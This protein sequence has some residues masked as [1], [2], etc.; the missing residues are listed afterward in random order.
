[1]SSSS[2]PV[3]ASPA[4]A[5]SRPL[6][7]MVR[8]LKYTSTDRQLEYLTIKLTRS[9]FSRDEYQRAIKSL[10]RRQKISNTAQ[11]KKRE[12]ERILIQQEREAER[13]AKEQARIVREQ[14]KQQKTL[15]KML[16]FTKVSEKAYRKYGITAYNFGPFGEPV[17][18][19]NDENMN[20]SLGETY[21]IT[22]KENI[23]FIRRVLLTAIAD[24]RK[25][26]PTGGKF[27]VQFRGITYPYDSRK[28]W[29]D[30]TEDKIQSFI[31]AVILWAETNSSPGEVNEK[32]ELVEVQYNFHII[33]I[34]VKAIRPLAGGCRN[35]E[36]KMKIAGA[37]VIDH[38][39]RGKNN[40][41]FTCCSKE[42]AEKYTTITR[43]SEKFFNDIRIKYSIPVDAM[44]DT[45][46]AIR[47][48][49]GEF[50]KPICI[51]NES[52]NAVAG[53]KTAQKK[54][55]LMNEHY[56]EYVGD[57]VEVKEC[58]KC[59]VEYMSKHDAR[60]CAMRRTYMMKQK[61]HVQERFVKMKSEKPGYN[62]QGLVLHYDIE[63][64]TKN[65]DKRHTPYIVGYCYYD[66]EGKQVY[67]TITGDR[68]MEQFY[69]FLGSE[70]VSH[71]KFIN[72]YKGSI[73]DH[74]YLMGVAWRDENAN[75][76]DTLLMNNGRILKAEIQGKNL[77]DLGNHLTG[78]LKQNLQGAGCAIQKGDIDHNTTNAWSKMPEQL[79]HDVKM[80]L[81]K[82]VLGL[83]ELYNKINADMY[84][85]EEVNLCDFLTTSHCAYTLWA[86]K[87]LDQPVYI[88]KPEQDKFIRQ[89]IYGGRCYKNKNRFTSAQYEAVKNGTLTNIEEIDDY[90]VYLDVVSLYPTSMMREYPVGLPENTTDY[91]EGKL[92]IY[93]INYKPNKSL[94]TPVLPRRVENSLKWDLEDGTGVYTSVDIENAKRFGYDIEVEYGMYWEES[95]P[96][97]KSYIEK[98]YQKKQNSVKDTAPYTTAK[99]YLN[100][101]YGKM[102]QRPIYT[103]TFYPKNH[104]ELQEVMCG[105]I[106]TEM[107]L[108]GDRLVVVGTPRE[109]EAV[110]RCVSKPTF[111]GAFILGYSREIMMGHIHNT[112]PDNTMENLFSYTDTDSLMTHVKSMANVKTGK[113]LG[114]LDNDLGTG[115]KIVRAIWISPKL[116]MLEYCY[117]DEKLGKVVMKNK[118][119]GKGLN[120]N[121]LTVE[122]Y[123]RMDAGQSIT[124]VADFQ[125]KRINVKRNKQEKSKD[126]FSVYH[127]NDTDT[128]AKGQP[129]LQKVVNTVAWKGRHFTDDNNS[130]PYGHNLIQHV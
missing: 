74:Y 22:A 109:E 123:E 70:D 2:A 122:L 1:M 7:E 37:E 34:I 45:M 10:N 18:H 100:G 98:F 91:K 105:H 38:Q 51:L 104:M 59:G 113:N 61:G 30:I 78:T 114:D 33:H 116:Y 16:K 79:Q 35:R 23:E 13:L 94:L 28:N 47:I 76:N 120:S 53:V 130:L 110:E 32:G 14:V 83:C 86:E 44:V 106:I 96:I 65:K 68:C 29:D 40:C 69:E 115:K 11:E 27:Q 60:A 102:I 6:V 119:R 4:P 117:Y 26:Y 95:A 81:E 124:N 93:K 55:M 17:D 67:N 49:S 8:P 41:F 3:S 84:D 54:L 92:G 127:I 39:S 21:G 24:F 129:V 56:M 89:S 48:F 43:F 82:D 103:K 42:F 111:C 99:L 128:N 19:E 112:N 121:K 58:E 126:Y 52:L 80:Y 97:F 72:A 62:T 50:D 5:L 66:A 36:K 118:M 88:P 101:L 25:T 85:S 46:G 125:M 107:E 31:D 71:I 20:I 57:A 73:F 9:Q 77:I 63:T 64:Q 108:V 90:M 87:Y 12:R 15:A 75:T